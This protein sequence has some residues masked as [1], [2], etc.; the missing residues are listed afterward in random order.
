MSAHPLR[1]GG[2]KAS[3]P[4][5]EVLRVGID[6]SEERVD[7]HAVPIGERR[8]GDVSQDELRDLIREAESQFRTR[9]ECEATH[10]MAQ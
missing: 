3:V 2:S 7:H 8:F 1:Q 9:T 10:A 4:V 6:G 5:E